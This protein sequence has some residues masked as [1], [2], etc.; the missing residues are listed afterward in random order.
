MKFRPFFM[1]LLS[2]IVFTVLVTSLVPFGVVEA[3]P[4]PVLQG[5]S[6]C[7]G[8]VPGANHVKITGYNFADLA[9]YKAIIELTTRE[10]FELSIGNITA[11]TF[12]IMDD[13]PDVYTG[14][15]VTAKNAKHRA[16]IQELKSF[17]VKKGNTVS[18]KLYLNI[19]SPYP[20]IDQ[21]A[22]TTV[23]PGDM[24]YV[25]GGNWDQTQITKYVAIFHLPKGT[26]KRVWVLPPPVPVQSPPYYQV[27][28]F[29]NITMTGL[30][31]L[32]I[33]E[34]F[35]GQSPAD[36]DAIENSP[37]TISIYGPGTHE[38]NEIEISIKTR[39]SFS[40]PY[41]VLLGPHFNN[42]E[43]QTTF[44]TGMTGITVPCGREPFI[45]NVKN[46]SIWTIVLKYRPRNALVP[47]SPWVTLNP[48]ESTSA[49]NVTHY[50]DKPDEPN[51][52][53]AIWEVNGPPSTRANR[54][55]LSIDIS[56]KK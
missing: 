7:C 13:I 29:P 12:E 28:H 56:W 9:L 11:T 2:A 3:Q 51:K 36:Q 14:Y 21:F 31:S 26:Q 15:N 10:K 37:V 43:Q 41:K 40:N 1:L 33:P 35:C 53:N 25:N 19:R 48:G 44:Y 38:S 30:L 32:K 8:A 4:V 54:L 42:N 39:S 34:V 24:I 20:I 50:V 23:S 46:T 47:D 5:M 18:N 27:P 16:R 45:T 22:K 17:Y 49:F 6:P 52:I 55:S